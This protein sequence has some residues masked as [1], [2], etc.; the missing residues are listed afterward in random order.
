M[1]LFSSLGLVVAPPARE[2]GQ[3]TSAISLSRLDHFDTGRPPLLTVRW[4]A[5]R[6]SPLA[7]QVAF[8]L[9]AS[10]VVFNIAGARKIFPRLA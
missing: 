4:P 10:G 1:R 2:P 9:Q 8:R 6:V 7:S 5:P 3:D